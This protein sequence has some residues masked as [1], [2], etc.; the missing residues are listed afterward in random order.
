MVVT[1]Y[2]LH[3]TL[4]AVVSLNGPGRRYPSPAGMGE[5]KRAAHFHTRFM[6]DGFG[7]DTPRYFF[8]DSA[9]QPGC[10]FGHAF[11][12]LGLG[13]QVVQYEREVSSPLELGIGAILREVGI[14]VSAQF[15]SACEVAQVSQD[16]LEPWGQ[17]MADF[18][19]E[20]VM[21]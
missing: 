4:H 11:A 17:V 8:R 19:A 13:E 14:D 1:Q 6:A 2:Q 20:L 9:E 12:M 21:E 15:L 18:E 7:G 5:R 16:A 3:V 10:L